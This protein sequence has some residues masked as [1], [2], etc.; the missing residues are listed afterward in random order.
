M[1]QQRGHRARPS[2]ACEP[3][4]EKRRK[5]DLKEPGCSQCRRAKVVCP[6]YRDAFTSRLRNWS[7]S[8]AARRAQGR[9]SNDRS[10]SPKT[11]TPRTTVQSSPFCEAASGTSF[12]SDSH[13]DTD[14]QNVVAQALQKK[15]LL[16]AVCV[17]TNLTEA[18]LNYFMHTYA[19]QSFFAYLPDFYGTLP[20]RDRDNLDFIISVPALVCLSQDLREPS[21]LRIAYAR[22]ANAIAS[23]QR[24]LASPH[25]ATLDATLLS[26]LL[27]GLF[28]ALVFQG[29][30][31]PDNWI[32]HL[33]G[34]AALLDMRGKSQFDSPL[35]RHL[36]IHS[37]GNIQAS[38]ALRG[39]PVPPF[40]KP[41]QQ[42][43]SSIVVPDHLGIRMGLV[44]DGFA[45]L[46]ADAKSLPVAQ[47]VQKALELDR[48]MGSL[49][50]A[51]NG[52]APYHRLDADS[53]GLDF[54]QI[55][56]YRDG[57]DHYPSPQVARR[58]NGL[59][60]IRL[61]VN[62]HISSALASIDDIELP[63]CAS[64]PDGLF[65]TPSAQLL[66]KAA[67]AAEA[68]IADMLHSV[69]YFIELSSSPRITARSLIFP[70]SA[71]AASELAPLSA[72][73]FARER[74]AYLGTGYGL[75]Q[76]RDSV[77]MVRDH[78]D[79]EDWILLPHWS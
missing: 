12:T 71:I 69:P 67:H 11:T 38:C 57:V 55:R 23:T 63:P 56:C 68:V 75:A 40:L 26:V 60:M 62:E 20:I 77:D 46:R 7:P 10:L 28:E 64:P 39:I 53:S 37:S 74:L 8:T 42:Y 19:V 6:G 1:Y 22:H 13:S 52:S 9:K 18:A 2:K 51:M 25:H 41:L 66:E 29:R 4:R 21:F 73:L 14:A 78:P 43:A 32:A 35:G 59:R 31:K 45:A 79:L 76:A 15:S 72:K 65:S 50:E 5:C 24:A 27:L 17:S 49:L 16:Q 54:H 70:L 30:R 3:C 44:L 36:F 48:E 61:F 58:W 34:S 33:Q 47:H